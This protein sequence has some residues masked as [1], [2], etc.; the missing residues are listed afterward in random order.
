MSRI[1]QNI[2]LSSTTKKEEIYDFLEK[3][4][5]NLIKNCR[6]RKNNN[7]NPIPFITNP[8]RFLNITTEYY[9]DLINSFFTQFSDTH[10]IFLDFQESLIKFGCQSKMI[11]FDIVLNRNHDENIEKIL[12]ENVSKINLKHPDIKYILIEEPITNFMDDVLPSVSCTIN[13]EDYN[14]YIKK[15]IQKKIETVNELSKVSLYNNRMNKNKAV[16]NVLGNSDLRRTIADYIGGKN[17]YK[18][19]KLKKNNKARKTYKIKNKNKKIE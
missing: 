14:K 13:I 1:I 5:D 15:E 11:L 9:Y 10:E 3:I 6:K 12:L 17:K 16:S 4:I 18:S 2:E 19:S 7:N 8:N